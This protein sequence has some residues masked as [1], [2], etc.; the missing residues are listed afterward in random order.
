MPFETLVDLPAHSFVFV[1]S[2]VLIYGLSGVS[3]QCEDLLDR[4][5]REELTGVTLYET[6]NEVTHR[7]MVAE[8]RSKGVITSGGARALRRSFRLIPTLQDYWNDT[9]RLLSLNLLFVPVSDSVLRAAQ[10]E[11]QAAGLLTNDS[12]IISCMR[13]YGLSFLATNDSDFERVHGITI[14]KPADLP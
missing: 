10:T 7:L 1:D 3:R 14:F 6:I 12:L 4:C 8:A 13:E 2:N 11:R 5:Q 9:L